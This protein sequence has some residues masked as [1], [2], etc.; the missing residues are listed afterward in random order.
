MN[1]FVFF[2]RV[3]NFIEY[4]IGTFFQ[5]IYMYYL[6][7]QSK[8]DDMVLFLLPDHDLRAGGT[9]SIYFMLSE[10]RK[11]YPNKMVLPVVL[12][13]R[14]HLFHPRW[15]DNN[16][17]VY[18]LK[19]LHKLFNKSNLI[20]LHVPEYY[21]QTLSKDISEGNYDFKK[22]K[23]N[24]LNQNAEYMPSHEVV[25]KYISLYRCVTMTLAFKCNEDIDYPYLTSRAYHLGAWF[26][27][28]VD[29]LVP[30]E[31]K[32]NLCIISPD[33]HPIKEAIVQLL[34]SHGIKCFQFKSIRFDRFQKIQERAKW[35]ISFGE[36]FDGYS[37]VEFRKGGVG[38]G[39]YSRFFFPKDFSEDNLP[40]SFFKTYE[41]MQNNI[42]SVMEY[43]N[44]KEHYE[45]YVMEM[46]N[47]L[48]KG[49]SAETI[50]S[51]LQNYYNHELN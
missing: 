30:F 21:Y 7:N 37:S 29:R 32:E 17:F 4:L 1:L 35:A 34:E 50:S 12:S 24:I 43:L 20:L 13:K 22:V 48:K 3:Y 19:Y 40:M 9:L 49:A 8:L 16:F 28:R 38:F 41:D 36:G 26:Y 11:M 18:N 44:D 5:K 31:E 6:G 47:Y 2:V 39:V 15:I 23:I 27:G 25:Q 46:Y 42:L 10:T 45:H 33:E 51:R 14:Q